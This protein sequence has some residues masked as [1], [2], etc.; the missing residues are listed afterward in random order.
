MNFTLTLTQRYD[1]VFRINLKTF[2]ETIKLFETSIINVLNLRSK[3]LFLYYE[4][5][6]REHFNFFRSV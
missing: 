5:S 4:K 1:N 3:E 2:N 6:V